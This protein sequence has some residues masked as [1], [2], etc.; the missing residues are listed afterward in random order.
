MDTNRIS[1]KI[2]FFTGRGKI[3][4]RESKKLWKYLVNRGNGIGSEGLTMAVF[5][6]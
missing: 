5:D 6:D 1:A 3:N 4:V 2:M